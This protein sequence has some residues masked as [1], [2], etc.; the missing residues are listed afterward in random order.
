MASPAFSVM[1]ANVVA[2]LIF[3]TIAPVDWNAVALLATGPVVGGYLGS[4][5]GRLLPEALLPRSPF[6]LA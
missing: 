1:A 2:T 3:I 4:H 5:L 6:W